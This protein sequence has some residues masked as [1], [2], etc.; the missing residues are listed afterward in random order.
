MDHLHEKDSIVRLFNVTKQ[1]GASQA[2]SNLSLDIKKNEFIM[3]SGPSGAGK[4]TLL[5]L[6][7]LAEPASEGQILV[8]GMNL[9]RINKK[10]LPFFR[11]HLGIIFQDFK[12]I[13]RRTVFEN[14]AIVLEA[15]GVPKNSIRKKVTTVLRIVEMEDKLDSLPPTLSGG[16]QQRVA[17]AR[18]VVGTPKIIIADEPTGS[19]D[20]KSAGIVMDL[21][22]R[23][24][25]AGT[26]VIMA[27]HS[28][29][30]LLN[31]NVR[32]IHIEKG[33]LLPGTTIL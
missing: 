29:E 22:K 19:L 30:H 14:V 7:Y 17:V 6:I 23:F 28:R 31:T 12:L 33:K 21:I 27:S 16:E 1:Y 4:S 20:S 9:S 25:A 15:A 24:H 3:V 8:D 26:T 18:A 10:A 11:R 2:L 5:K 32:T 13:P